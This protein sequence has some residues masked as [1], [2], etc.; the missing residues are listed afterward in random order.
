MK[1]GYSYFMSA[2]LVFLSLTL[3]LSCGDDS[4]SGAATLSTTDFSINEES[5][6]THNNQFDNN[7]RALIQA[8]RGTWCYESG[9][10]YYLGLTFDIDPA[11]P[12]QYNV[13]AAAFFD[14]ENRLTTYV[15]GGRLNYKDLLTAKYRRDDGAPILGIE[16]LSLPYQYLDEAYSFN[17]FSRVV[18]L[19]KSFDRLRLNYGSGQ[20]SSNLSGVFKK[21]YSNATEG[22]CHSIKLSTDSKNSLPKKDPFYEPRSSNPRDSLRD[23]MRP[24]CE[25][26]CDGDNS[27]IEICVE[28]EVCL[29][30]CENDDC[31]E[32]CY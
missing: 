11:M 26:E 4:S 13:D 17:Y 16:I 15:S 6:K 1:T 21:S 28:R 8:L 14:N 19:N 18:F 27:C 30:T 32:A 3:L 9:F 29:V 20:S 22:Q 23:G 24:Y 25:M 5:T 31:E 12:R 2:S 10:P 7:D